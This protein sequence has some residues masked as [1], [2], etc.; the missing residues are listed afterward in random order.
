LPTPLEK[1]LSENQNS[2]EES[3]EL[4]PQQMMMPKLLENNNSTYEPH[5]LMSGHSGQINSL[6]V[7]DPEA[8]EDYGQHC[9][10]SGGNDKTIRMWRKLDD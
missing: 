8:M 6:C 9:F 5:S 1:K 7:M 2:N 3:A 4:D 10:F